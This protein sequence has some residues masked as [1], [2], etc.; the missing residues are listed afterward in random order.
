MIQRQEYWSFWSCEKT[1]FWIKK[2]KL[3]GHN[4]LTVLAGQ[5]GWG[6]FWMLNGCRPTNAWVSHIFFVGAKLV[7]VIGSPARHI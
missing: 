3:G 2:Q 6:A 5:I 7:S 1:R 4:D